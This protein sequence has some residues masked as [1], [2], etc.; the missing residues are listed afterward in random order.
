MIGNPHTRILKLN[1]VN[2]LEREFFSIEICHIKHLKAVVDN[3][4]QGQL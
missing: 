3:L 1:K 4:A 2:Q